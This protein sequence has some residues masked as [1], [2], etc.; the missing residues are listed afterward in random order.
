MGAMGGAMGTESKSKEIVGGG[1]D[2]GTGGTKIC[3]TV[4][5]PQPPPRY[6]DGPGV[7]ELQEMQRPNEIRWTRVQIGPARAPALLR[8]E[9]YS[10]KISQLPGVIGH[11]LTMQKWFRHDRQ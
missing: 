9:V 8:L 10:R 4:C 6:L 11:R 2:A 5:A 7:M 3:A 1:V